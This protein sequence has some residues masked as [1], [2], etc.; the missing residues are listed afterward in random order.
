MQELLAGLGVA[1]G[2]AL[3][4]A[5]LVANS[6]ITS[7]AGE[8]VRGIAGSAQL[9]LAAR[10]TDGFSQRVVERVRVLPDVRVASPLLEQRAAVVG[11]N[12]RSSVNLVGVDVSI[13]ELNGSAT[14][15][16]DPVMLV[17][18]VQAPPDS[19]KAS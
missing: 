7:N 14:R 13:V 8:L 17:A 5:V 4:F 6:S 15:D 19:S 9:E 11:P 3:V 16:L 12:G 2:V 1:I 10:S 18:L